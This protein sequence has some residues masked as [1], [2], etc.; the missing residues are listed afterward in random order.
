MQLENIKQGWKSFAESKQG[1]L[2]LRGIRWIFTIAIF[3]Y[4]I[5]Q[6]NEIGW[7]AILKSLPT[8]PWFYIIF[9]ITY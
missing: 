1:K 8:T 6:L 3:A 5:Y 2:T 4:L 7:V 9:L